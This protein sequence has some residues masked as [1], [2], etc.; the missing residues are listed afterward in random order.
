MIIYVLFCHSD[1][2]VLKHFRSAAELY[3]YY[4][5]LYIYFKTHLL[6]AILLLFILHKNYKKVRPILQQIAQNIGNKK[7]CLSNI[8]IHNQNFTLVL[9]SNIIKYSLIPLNLL[10]T[11]NIHSPLLTL[12]SNTL[13]PLL[14]PTTTLPL[15]YPIIHLTKTHIKKLH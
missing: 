8:H 12:S 13:Y 10:N 9:L 1:F 15:P 7:R 3:L 11:P 2:K 14:H 6:Q 5:M 4:T